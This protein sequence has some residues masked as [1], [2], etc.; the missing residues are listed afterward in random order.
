MK[1]RSINCVNFTNAESTESLCTNK[2]YYLCMFFVCICFMTK[3]GQNV[4]M[5]HIII[6][7]FILV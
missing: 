7:H 2:C 6:F 3:V 4:V 5:Y 1:S